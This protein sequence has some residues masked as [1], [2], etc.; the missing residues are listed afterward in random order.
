[1]FGKVTMGSLA[2][3]LLMGTESVEA[4]S[5]RFN[6]WN[7]DLSLSMIE[8]PKHHKKKLA[9]KQKKLTK[10]ANPEYDNDPQP[11]AH[12]N[13]PTGPYGHAH[14]DRVPVAKKSIKKKAKKHAQVPKYEEIP[15]ESSVAQVERMSD[16]A[17]TSLGCKTDTVDPYT[18]KSDPGFPTGY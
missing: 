3:A 17:C 16:P 4:V 11:Q 5:L 15:A 12:P 13:F 18:K 6:N 8:K 1:M 9:K 7:P 14:E 10:W 2:L